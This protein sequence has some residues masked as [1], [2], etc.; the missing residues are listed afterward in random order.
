MYHEEC[1]HGDGA[2]RNESMNCIV[3]NERKSS[4]VCI[5]S[6]QVCG[7]HEGDRGVVV[8]DIG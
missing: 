3:M 7:G 8:G 6:K 1:S 4:T 2:E 5:I